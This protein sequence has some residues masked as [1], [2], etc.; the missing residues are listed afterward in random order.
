MVKQKEKQQIVELVNKPTPL[1]VIKARS[2]ERR[3][4]QKDFQGSDKREDVRRMADLERKDQELEML[5]LENS[6]LQGRNKALLVSRPDMV[7]YYAALL[8]SVNVIFGWMA[9]FA[10]S[11]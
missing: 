8:L 9:Y 7:L 4:N 3:Q 1:R 11:I 5:K 10:I 2:D 6:R